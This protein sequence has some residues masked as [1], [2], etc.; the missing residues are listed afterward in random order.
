VIHW[1]TSQLTD[2]ELRKGIADCRSALDQLT[3]DAAVRSD[4]TT[5]LEACEA[6]LAGRLQARRAPLPTAVS[7]AYPDDAS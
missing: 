6:E 1:K 3:G 4:L 2:F 5:R 7:F